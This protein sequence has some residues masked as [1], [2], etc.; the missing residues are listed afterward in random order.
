MDKL[1][2]RLDDLSSLPE[3]I[4]PKALYG[5]GEDGKFYP[6]VE[7]VEDGT[8]RWA[9][10]NVGGLKSSLGKVK[11]E[12]EQVRGKLG[13]FGEITAEQ[14]KAALEKLKE[15]E[16]AAPE[17]Q[18]NARLQTLKT[19]L[20]KKHGGEVEKLNA[21]LQELT[22]ALEGALIDAQVATIMATEE[23]L[24]GSPTLIL[25]H[26]R[27]ATKLHR[28]GP[29]DYV[30][31][32]VDGDG[33]ARV[34]PTSGQTGDMSLKELLGEFKATRADLAGAFKG[35]AATGS[36]ADGSQT[37]RASGSTISMS[38]E[39]AKDVAKYRAA[40]EEAAKSGRTIQLTE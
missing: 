17:E 5:Q 4:D 28:R 7:A 26:V 14:A 3:T 35:T 40:K 2:G 24:E 15:L 9:F 13:S 36:G 19:E 21:Q 31:Q 22:G 16:G 20:E 6:K 37:G 11:G 1:P 29:G 23:E 18:V 8:A 33:H 30:T 27:K 38:R 25:P 34:S 39:D 12:L 32:V 10:E